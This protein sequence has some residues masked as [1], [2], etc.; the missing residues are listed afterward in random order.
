MALQRN[1]SPETALLYD[2]ARGI[3]MYIFLVLPETFLEPSWRSAAPPDPPQ[4]TAIVTAKTSLIR[5]LI[6]GAAAPPQNT[7]IATAEDFGYV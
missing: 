6:G 7:D 5:G 2:T 4:N 1:L 3:C